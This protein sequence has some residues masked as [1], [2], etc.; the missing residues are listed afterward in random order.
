LGADGSTAG[1]DLDAVV[2]VVGEVVGK[3]WELV[4]FYWEIT[5]RVSSQVEVVLVLAGEAF[6]DQTVDVPK[7]FV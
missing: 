4:L 7:K 5:L 1:F 6:L 2:N 3:A